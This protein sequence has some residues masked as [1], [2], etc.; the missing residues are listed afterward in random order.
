MTLEEAKE[1]FIA[2]ANRTIEAY[3]ELEAAQAAER[4]AR[5]VYE[6]AFRAQPTKE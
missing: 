1:A 6:R 3:R 5:E 4:K 2:A